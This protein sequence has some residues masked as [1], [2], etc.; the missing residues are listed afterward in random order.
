MLGVADVDAAAKK[1]VIRIPKIDGLDWASGV[2]PVPGGAIKLRWEKKADGEIAHTLEA[3]DGYEV[4]V[5]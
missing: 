4:V 3:P 5:E 2:Q 1:I